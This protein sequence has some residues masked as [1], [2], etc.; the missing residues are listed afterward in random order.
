MLMYQY[1]KKYYPDFNSEE[2]NKEK[3]FEALYPGKKFSPQ[4]IKTLTSLLEKLC[5]EYL[6]HL[7]LR[8]NM[9]D[10]YWLL[11][12]ELSGRRLYK[13]SE[14]IITEGEEYLNH[15]GTDVYYYKSMQELEK[16][17]FVNYYYDKDKPGQINCLTNI[18]DLFVIHALVETLQHVL[19]LFNVQ[20][21]Y[22][23]DLSN[24][25]LMKFYDSI[26]ID[27]MVEWVK[28]KSKHSDIVEFYADMVKLTNNIDDDK[29]FLR[30]AEFFSSL[31][32]KLSVFGRYNL[33]YH[34]YPLINKLKQKDEEKFGKELFKVY[35]DMLRYN[36]YRQTDESLMQPGIYRG[37]F[38]A[39]YEVN[40]I[41]WAREFAENYKTQVPE[42]FRNEM[43]SFC[44]A[45]LFFTEGEYDKALEQLNKISL[46][47]HSLKY[48]VRF[49]IIMI[50]YEL[51]Y[52]EETR[53]MIDSFRNFLKENKFISKEIKLRHNSFL[54]YIKEVVRLREAHP[55]VIAE[56]LIKDISK[57]KNIRGRKWLIKKVQELKN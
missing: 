32:E 3:V 21:L 2:L 34:F 33:F 13:M 24:Q 29:T 54:K 36:A 26:D 57:E 41:K 23:A 45:N 28:K 4:T 8:G 42:E 10:Y 27:R 55:D 12:A 17:K 1:L 47:H 48:D 52:L 49:L 46:D 15:Q 14:K 39:A 53:S 31:V 5:E 11:S 30:V 51:G 22:N 38:L 16:N 19:R 37:I 7:A 50:Y 9:F 25:L 40:E 20:E 18:G 44:N 43:F 56:K 6:Y 35:K